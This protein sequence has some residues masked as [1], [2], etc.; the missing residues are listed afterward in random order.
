MNETKKMYW[1]IPNVQVMNANN[2]YNIYDKFISKIYG[3]DYNELKEICPIIFNKKDNPN[4][5]G[6]ILTLINFLGL[7]QTR[8]ENNKFIVEEN[9]FLVTNMT[10]SDFINIYLDYSLAYFQYP[11]FNQSYENRNIKIR[12]PYLLILSLLSEL[13]KVDEQ[14][15]YLT[16]TE[17]Y[18]LFKVSNSLF[19]SYEDIDIELAFEIIKQRK[20][21][22][23]DI[24][25]I[26]VLAYDIT[27]LRNSSL[28]SFESSDY[29]VDEDFAFGLSKEYGVD[30]KI[31]WLL[32]D[33]VK[34]DICEIDKSLCDKENATKW[35]KFL[36]NKD[37][38]DNW[39]QNVFTDV[40]HNELGESG[41]ESGIETDSSEDEDVFTT[42]FNPD[43]ISIQTKPVVLE[44]LLR[45]IKKNE[46]N[47]NP[48]FQRK[49]VWDIEKKSR[50]IES[51]ML[52]IPL[53]MFYVSSDKDNNWTVVDGL[54]RLSTIKEFILGNYDSEKQ[55]YD[56]NGFKLKKLEFWT[57]L[58]GYN[59]H[60]EKFPG[61]PFNN[62]M[63]TE[64]SFTIINPDTPEE[65][66]RNI[67]KRINTGGMPLTLQEIR[68]ALYQGN[69]TAL[70]EELV[71][72]EYFLNAVEKI[73][74]SRMSGRELI[75]RFLS[76]YIR[77]YE[78][79]TRDSS[80]DNHLSTTMRIINVLND[81]TFEK[82]KEE[83][84]NDKNLDLNSLY[85]SINTVN[86]E[87]LK[88][89]FEL[90]MI[91]NRQLFGSHTFRKSF[92]GKRRTAINKT[93]F[94]VFSNLLLTLSEDQFNMLLKN[95]KEFLQEYKEKYLLIND[96]S[97]M[98]GRDSHKVSSVKA[99]YEQLI[100]LLK[101]YSKGI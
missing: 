41:S 28:L 82:K 33:Q 56:E 57:D 16:K 26:R 76:F 89:D 45:R 87:K 27:Y 54:Q 40:I 92:P 8:K 67:F 66:K 78:Y 98:I 12:K 61:K 2:V 90:T 53:P 10:N 22:T 52:N 95:K 101:K 9:E 18:E 72:N 5:F 6:Q 30:D 25:K 99:R 20:N 3:R 100:V 47:L 15:A 86:I 80:M 58:E 32:S 39:K 50:L 24:N 73:D 93:L 71:E 35:A 37:R 14:E 4:Y 62:I 70:L 1:N 60:D 38:F 97:N 48:A 29:S 21:N 13:K 19:R 94:E 74:D 68:H 91:R 79:Y 17:F 11:R 59:I 7:L 23:I 34:N 36:N 96:F 43:E 83:F 31:K 81:L 55:K 77:N 69:S 51:M 75:L 44:G 42:P 84:K 85:M 63:E 46:I 65:V 49:T 64:L 88:K